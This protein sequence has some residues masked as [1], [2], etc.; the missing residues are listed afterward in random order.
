[1]RFVSAEL[2]ETFERLARQAGPR[3]MAVAS[4][5]SDARVRLRRGDYAVVDA[6]DEAIRSGRTSVLV[7]DRAA[8]AGAHLFSNEHLHAKVLITARAVLVGS[9][10]ISQSA[11]KQIEAAIASSNATV[12]GDAAAW[13]EGLLRRS[14]RI[15]AEF[16]DHIKRIP[17][18]SPLRGFPS[19]PTLAE[20]LTADLPVLSDYVWSWYGYG[21][22]LSERVV[23]RLALERKLLPPRTPS[24]TWKWL[25]WDYHS[26]LITQIHQVYAGKPAVRFVGRTGD[27]G[28]ERLTTLDTRTSNFVG[29]F[30]VLG[31]R[32]DKVA[33]ITLQQNAPGLRLS[34]AYW[35]TEL[36][37]RLT[38]GLKAEPKLAKQLFERSTTTMTL[39]ELQK[40][41]AA[42]A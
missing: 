37:R 31:K 41:Y 12:R 33:V 36:C 30:R 10:N 35:R 17:V 3:R 1:M 39:S 6:S 13:F 38:R 29:A 23:R 32:Y 24:R 18:E 22:E 26:G 27:K 21:A 8:T 9:A 16:L 25:E 19:K 34:G 7:L 2:W 5:S 4:L 11:T 40:L 14:R 20:A 42:G 28:L 15:D